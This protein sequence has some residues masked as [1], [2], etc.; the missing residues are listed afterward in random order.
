MI[1]LEGL[2]FQI[3]LRL[4]GWSLL[5]FCR[6][7]GLFGQVSCLSF[8]FEE[9]TFFIVDLNLIKFYF[10]GLNALVLHRFLGH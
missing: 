4:L 8:T 2:T 9:M 3:R 7:F 5:L 1:Y 10:I 6:L